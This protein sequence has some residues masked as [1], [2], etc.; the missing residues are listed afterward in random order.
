MPVNDTPDNINLLSFSPCHWGRA[1]G[2]LN[3]RE[4]FDLSNPTKKW[5]ERK[6]NKNVMVTYPDINITYKSHHPTAFEDDQ[7]IMRILSHPEQ[8]DC[9]PWIQHSG[10]SPRFRL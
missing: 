5:K 1:I 9:F 4:L 7:A 10:P 2:M 3:Y 8:V 6:R